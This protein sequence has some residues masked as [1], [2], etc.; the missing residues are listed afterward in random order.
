[1][2]NISDYGKNSGGNF[3][4]KLKNAAKMLSLSLAAAVVISG[5]SPATSNAKV[6]NINNGEDSISLSYANFAFHYTQSMYDVV[7]RSYYGDDYWTQDL[8]SD[9]EENMQASIKKELMDDLENAW[10]LRKHAEEYGVTLSD[11]EKTKIA[12]AAK[13]FLSSNKKA[14]VKA[15]GANEELVKRYLED[16][17]YKEKVEKA[18]KDSFDISVS[19]EEAKQKTVTYVKIDEDKKSDA[20]DLAKIKE[21]A[22][23][24]TVAEE[25][26]LKADSY[27][28]GKDEID[29]AQSDEDAGNDANHVLP[30]DVLKAVDKLAN[31]K[32][33]DAIHVEGDGYYVC[34]MD[35]DDDE[36][37]TNTAR[38][39]MI[40]TK[41]SEE[42]DTLLQGWK[43]ETD[44]KIDEKQWKKVKVTD[45]FEKVNTEEE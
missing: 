19:D 14:T 16:S 30:L 31:G 4:M 27:S 25:K 18:I 17:F 7:Y 29:S 42:Y 44:W 43:D 23:L 20:E 3:K 32:M 24:E 35:N 34:R 2:Y 26:G 9:G 28:F 45:L 11:D 13:K 37:A 40:L 22:S 1:M 15:L 12:E 33:T 36:E 38:E 41:Q 6:V 21:S 8:Y 10:I 5:C 39:S